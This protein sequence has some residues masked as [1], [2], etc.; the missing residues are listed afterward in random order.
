MAEKPPLVQQQAGVHQS[1]PKS[2]LKTK[3]RI[4]FLSLGFDHVAA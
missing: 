4:F 3:V 2:L 1:I